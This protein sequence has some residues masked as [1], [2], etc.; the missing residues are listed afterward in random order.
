MLSHIILPKKQLDLTRLILN[1]HEGC[2]THTP[3]S[4]DAAGNNHVFL[5]F[6]LLMQA[7]ELLKRFGPFRLAYLE[8]LIRAADCRASGVSDVE[9]QTND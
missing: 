6:L 9:G 8:A 1:M 7:L 4:H 2:T 3:K 5:G